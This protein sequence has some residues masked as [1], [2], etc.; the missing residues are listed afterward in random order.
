[1]LRPVPVML[2]LV[3]ALSLSACGGGSGLGGP[4]PGPDAV[5][6]P[7]GSLAPVVEVIEPASGPVI[8]GTRIVI[9]GARLRSGGS[10]TQVLI[11]EAP[12]LDTI[13]VD[14]QTIECIVPPH[15]PGSVEGASRLRDAFKYRG[16]APRFEARDGKVGNASTG[17][18]TY[19]QVARDG[20]RVY[21]A[22]VDG[23]D[24]PATLRFNR[25][26]DGGRTWMPTDLVIRNPLRDGLPRGAST[27]R[28]EIFPRLACDGEDVYLLWEARRD[29]VR[30]VLFNRS[31]DAGSTWLPTPIAVMAEPMIAKQRLQPTMAVSGDDLYV[32]WSDPRNGETDIFFNRSTDGGL[33]WLPEEI[34]I[35]DDLAGEARSDFPSIACAGA[36]VYVTWQD[37]RD[38]EMSVL[39][40]RSTDG[41]LS[42]LDQDIRLD[43][44][45]PGKQLQ[46]IPPEMTSDG[47]QVYVTWSQVV[48]D[49]KA[50]VFVNASHD[51]GLSWLA[52]PRRVDRSAIHSSQPEIRCEGDDVYVIWIELL[53]NS[54]L[55]FSRSI[56]G[57]RT[58]LPQPVRIDRDPVPGQFY[59]LHPSFHVAGGHVFVV[60]GDGQ[61]ATDGVF[62]NFSPDKG[63]T[64]QPQDIRVNTPAAAK[65]F[66]DQPQ[67]AMDGFDV[68][69]VWF[70]SRNR[71]GVLNNEVWSNVTR[72]P[73][74]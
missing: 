57:G 7:S 42:W 5:G 31:T 70:D 27:S 60:W 72:A 63:D 3:V 73:G 19:L 69:V 54:D 21:S 71:D 44:A 33:T 30:T 15:T 64:W 66:G 61:D 26:L 32:A 40:N 16:F 53:N 25:S 47:K 29:G 6:A 1:M 50:Q 10:A 55:L 38:D 56:D 20:S 24:L 37:R 43:D 22:W 49:A 8:G 12:A 62:L 65:S 9:R 51:G 35:G 36:T 74:E 18:R 2:V 41:G 58:W 59:S 68:C 28:F 17:G 45:E 11:G 39:F 4:L 46:P 23:R 67:L 52:Q 14:E 13:V 34:R 48:G